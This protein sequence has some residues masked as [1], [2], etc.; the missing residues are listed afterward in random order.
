MH[1]RFVLERNIEFQCHVA[2]SD[3]KKSVETE[4][5]IF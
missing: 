3:L 5:V 2:M 1:V 4:G